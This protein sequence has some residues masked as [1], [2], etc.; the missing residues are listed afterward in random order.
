VAPDRTRH[1]RPRFL[2]S[3]LALASLGLIFAYGVFTLPGWPA[4]KVPQITVTAPIQACNNN[5]AAGLI[6]VAVDAL[7]QQSCVQG[8]TGVVNEDDGA[9]SPAVVLDDRDAVE[10]SLSNR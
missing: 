10:D 2:Q 5:V 6:A 7:T 4:G 8:D 3:S 1:P 9:P